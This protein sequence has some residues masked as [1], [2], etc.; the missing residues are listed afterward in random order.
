MHTY[1]YIYSRCCSIIKSNPTLCDPTDYS[2]P[3]S[4]VFHQPLSLLR[5][6]CI[7]SVM[8]SNHLILGCPLL[9]FLLPSIFP[10]IWVFSNE[11]AL[12]IKWPKYWSFS[13]SINPSNEYSGLIFFRVDR[14]NPL[15]VQRTLKNLL[16][17]HNL[18]AYI[19]DIY[20]A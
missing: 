3:G 10:R 17:H 15:V 18:K 5:F 1:I 11:S 19:F 13:F 4:S 9:L 8:L 12:H 2:M 20:N 7:E 14:F 6:M 16:Q